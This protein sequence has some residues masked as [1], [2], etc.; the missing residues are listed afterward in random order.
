MG[1]WAFRDPSGTKEQERLEAGPW[2]VLDACSGPRL[3]GPSRGHEERG[4]ML[5]LG[6]PGCRHKGLHLLCDEPAG[7]LSG[8][9]PTQGIM[10]PQEAG[11]G[12]RRGLAPEASS[13]LPLDS[14]LRLRIPHTGNPC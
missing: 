8:V 12:P 9:W 11:S 10:T 4:L 6:Q 1:W 3:H 5:K 13:G 2:N 14:G 7:D